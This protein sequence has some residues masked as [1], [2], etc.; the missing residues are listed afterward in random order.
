[1]D[2]RSTPQH[3]KKSTYHNNGV[4]VDAYDVTDQE[5]IFTMVK[6]K[7]SGSL[8]FTVSRFLFYVATGLMQLRVL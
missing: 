3:E 1:M 8:T 7:R 2:T 4:H 5:K 6:Y